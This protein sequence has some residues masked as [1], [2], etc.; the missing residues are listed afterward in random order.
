MFYVPILFSSLG[1]SRETSLL[2]AV[3]IG[4]VNLVSTF[5]SIF[6]VDRAG[7]R[8]LFLEGGAQMFISQIVTGVVLAVEFGEWGGGAW[9]GGG[10]WRGPG[11]GVVSWGR[12]G[13]VPGCGCWL[14]PLR[15]AVGGASWPVWP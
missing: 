2:N 4:A 10:G 12:V 8:T 14:P 13:A 3:I 11:R 15:H 1:S 7:R 6:A 9:W 5:V